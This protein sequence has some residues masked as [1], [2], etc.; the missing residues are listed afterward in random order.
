MSILLSKVNFCF[1]NACIIKVYQDSRIVCQLDIGD[2]KGLF[3]FGF[4]NNNSI[5]YLSVLMVKLIIFLIFL[6]E[7][8]IDSSAKFI[9]ACACSHIYFFPT[10]MIFDKL[11]K[12]G[13]FRV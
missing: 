1:G 9:L 4:I 13:L 7:Y 5:P 10:V 2:I 11:A 3:V 6:V 8:I 12:S